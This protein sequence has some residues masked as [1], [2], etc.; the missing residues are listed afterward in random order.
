MIA[1]DGSKFKAVNSKE[2]NHVPSKLKYRIERVENHIEA[3]L[4]RLEKTDEGDNS[5]NDSQPL[6][7]KLNWLNKKLKMLKEVENQVNQN[8]EKQISLTDPD[9]RLMKTN[10]MNRLVAYN[11]QSAVDTQH[12]LI[13]AHE[14]TNKPDRGQ[15]S[16]IAKLA[17]RA[18]GTEALTVIADKGYYSGPD[19]KETMDAGMSVFVP[20][21]DTSGSRKL[22][23]FNRSEFNYDAQSDAYI[24]PANQTLSYRLSSV[25]KG[26]TIRKYFTDAVT[27]RNCPMKP[28]CSTSPA[29]RRI[30][31]WE[32]QSSLDEMDSVKKSLPNAMVI[33]KQTVEHPFGTIKSWMGATH[34]LMKRFE[35]VGTEMNL[36]VLAYNMKRVMNIMGVQQMMEAIRV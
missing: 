14:V 1:I 29:R 11:I 23:I 30:S 22:G 3:Y 31:R 18:I 13:V 34:F 35:H 8:P 9:S 26:M 4:E 27:C 10:G 2:K 20:K 21:V 25:E 17:Q 32:H 19:I 28:Q 6:Q 16:P 15:L 24:C 36:H 7:E 33:R 12:H 5:T